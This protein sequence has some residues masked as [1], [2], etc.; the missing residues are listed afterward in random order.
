[1]VK[2]IVSACIASVCVISIYKLIKEI[3]YL[4]RVASDTASMQMRMEILYSKLMDRLVAEGLNDR[5]R[6]IAIWDCLSCYRP[7]AI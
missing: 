4:D 5:A 7:A 6:L 3:K 1:M 2:I